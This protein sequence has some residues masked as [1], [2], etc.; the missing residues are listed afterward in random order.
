MN[1]NSGLGPGSAFSYILAQ[2]RLDLIPELTDIKDE[3]TVITTSLELESKLPD[4]EKILDL[5]E[6]A[7]DYTGVLA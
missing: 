2:G 1:E 6:E 7:T 3:I 4:G 5:A